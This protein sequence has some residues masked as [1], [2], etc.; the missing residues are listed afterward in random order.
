M[1]IQKFTHGSCTRDLGL[2]LATQIVVNCMRT[3]L[4][5]TC[6]SAVEE[7]NKG[8]CQEICILGEGDATYHRPLGS[9]WILIAIPVA[10]I[11]A[12]TPQEK[13]RVMNLLESYTSD[14]PSDQ[15]EKHAQMDKLET[16]AAY[17]SC[18]DLS[19]LRQN[20]QTPG[21]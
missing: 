13:T 19:S 10:Y 9:A 18:S 8:L 21:T 11:G 15:R 16:F 1:D 14:L 7:D 17:L 12:D 5:G 4:Q 20:L 2:T 3:A 6:S